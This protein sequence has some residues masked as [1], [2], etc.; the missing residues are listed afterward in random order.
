MKAQTTRQ[1]VGNGLIIWPARTVVGA[2]NVAIL[3]YECDSEV[4]VLGE[5][6]VDI[7]DKVG[8]SKLSS[9]IAAISVNPTL[10]TGIAI[11]E[12][13]NELMSVIGNIMKRN[14]DDYVDLFE[15]AYGTDKPQTARVET[16]D[17]P[18]LAAIE[19]EFTV[20]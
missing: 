2:L 16:Y 5:T 11:G 15:G 17:H 1:F 9:L 6:L 14:R 18:D 4:R 20:S 3:V 7:H 8:S 13:V 19:L 12:A 10:A